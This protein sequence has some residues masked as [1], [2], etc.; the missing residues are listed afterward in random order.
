M[1]KSVAL[2]GVPV[3]GVS[4]AGLIKQL[5]SEYGEGFS[6]ADAEW[7]VAQVDAD[8]NA[9]AATA[10]KAYLDYSAFSRDELIDQL[11]YGDKFTV[12]QAVYAANAVGL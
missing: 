1:R 2:A 12:A 7:A 3:P 6:L 10:A 11:V 9:E 4:K 8:W 5:L